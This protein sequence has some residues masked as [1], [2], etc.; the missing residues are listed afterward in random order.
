MFT[1]CTPELARLLPKTVLMQSRELQAS[2]G[3][4]LFT[5]GE[6]PSHMFFVLTGEVVLERPGSKG[7]LV[8]LQRVRQG[9]IGEASL[10]S[11]RYHCHGLV[12]SASRLVQIPAHAIRAA[13]ETDPAFAGRWIQM[14]SQELKRLRLQC[15]RLALPK[16]QDRLL[17]L[18]ETE[19]DVGRYPLGAGLKSLS[20]QLGVTHEALYRCVALMEKQ[21]LIHRS[22]GDLCFL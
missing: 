4:R 8:V 14:L 19:G 20:A 5:T 15:E 6:K 12:I 13:L 1:N 10:N 3:T 17:H 9:F 11:E 7:E 18:V 2:K 21:G 22:Q 16:L